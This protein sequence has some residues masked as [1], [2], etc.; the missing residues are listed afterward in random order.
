[1]SESSIPRIL[2]PAPN[3][4]ANSTHGTIRLSD[5]TSKG[6]WVMLFSHPA[7]FTPV[8]TTEFIE[9]ARR[10]ED[11]EELNVQLIGVSI[12]SVYS[13]IAWIRELE[14]IAGVEIKFPVIADLDQRVSQ[15]YGLVHEVAC[16]TSTVRSVFVIDPKGN[17]RALLYYPMQLG[18]NVDELLRIFQGLQTA[19]ANGVSCPVNWQPGQQVIVAAPLTTEEAAKRLNGGGEGFD[20]TTWYLARKDLPAQIR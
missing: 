12:D 6:T 2:E 9:L 18:R 1:M 8:C 13:H 7:D 15:A 16:D 5:Y 4:E 11:F 10:Q 20:V 17:V 3:F 14:A 19:D